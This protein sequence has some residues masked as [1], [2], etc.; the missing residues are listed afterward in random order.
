MGWTKFNFDCFKIF[1]VSKTQQEAVAQCRK[2]EINGD[3][4]PIRSKAELNFVSNLISTS[5][6]TEQMLWIG[7]A[8]GGVE[9]GWLY[10]DGSGS[11]KHIDFYISPVAVNSGIALSAD[12]TLQ[13]N[14]SDIELPFLCR[15]DPAMSYYTRLHSGNVCP[16]EMTLVNGSCIAPINPSPLASHLARQDCRETFGFNIATPTSESRWRQQLRRLFTDVKWYD[17]FLFY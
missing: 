14:D 16:F 9:G 13:T 7:I 12:G 3:L 17:T 2:P 5:N 4:S 11:V 8:S 1:N 6:L 15:K 10:L